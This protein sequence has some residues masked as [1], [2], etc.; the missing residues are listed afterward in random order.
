MTVYGTNPCLIAGALLAL[1]PEQ[2]LA[3]LP[4]LT[5]QA[6]G[7]A[8]TLQAV[9]P[10]D[11]S[12][13]WVGGHGGV[14][15]RT[16]DGGRTWVRLKSPG[17]DSLQFRDVYAVSRDSAYVLSAGP[18]AR[19]RIY[20][21]V[22]GGVTWRLQFLNRD[23]SAFYDCFDFWNTAHGIALSDAVGGRLVL[24]ATSDGGT[25][26]IPLPSQESPEAAPGEGGFAASGT[27]LVTARSAYV[28]ITTGSQG[29]GKVYR[30]TDRGQQWSSV[31]LP[32]A[33]GSPTAGAMTLAFRD[34]LHG[35]ALGG[36]L[37]APDAYRDNVARTVDGGRTAALWRTG[38]RLGVRTCQGSAGAGGRGSRRVRQLAGRWS[39]LDGAVCPGVLGSGSGQK[40]GLDGGAC[41]ADHPRG[42]LAKRGEGNGWG[43]ALH[44]PSLMRAARQ[45]EQ[46]RGQHDQ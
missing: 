38:V 32:L 2:A 27:C 1:G 43:M 17:G 28:W 18:G 31:T 30:S 40:R 19:S 20:R 46:Q 15:L 23:S 37:G 35:V 4:G 6:S 34:T 39:H 26:W 21:T 13:A 33:S 5:E 44:R 10:V 9:S 25:T 3:Q 29:L 12:T 41:R 36:D 22:D 8:V 45:T 14:I 16:V 24:I 11:D 42:L 7:V